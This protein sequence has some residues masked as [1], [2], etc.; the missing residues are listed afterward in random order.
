V[1]DEP[2]AA[3]HVGEVLLPQPDDALAR[4]RRSP[5]TAVLSAADGFCAHPVRRKRGMRGR[6]P[7]RP[8]RIGAR[9]WTRTLSS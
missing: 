2:L 7:S 9:P 8:D 6:S 1:R 4:G 3:V 5:R